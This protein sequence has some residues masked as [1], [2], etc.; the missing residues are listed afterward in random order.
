MYV[1]AYNLYVND[2]ASFVGTTEN[3]RC[4]SSTDKKEI[5]LTPDQYNDCLALAFIIDRKKQLE[6]EVRKILFQE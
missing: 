2:Q 4:D 1:P 3:K 5:E 6:I